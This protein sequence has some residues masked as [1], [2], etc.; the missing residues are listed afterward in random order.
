VALVIRL[1]GVPSIERD[2]VPV[3]LGGRKPWA[4]LAMLALE[5]RPLPRQ[6]LID[7][8]TPEAD[9][10]QAALRWLLHAVRRA[11]GPEATVAEHDGQL[12]LECSEAVEVDVIR[13]TEGS[14]EDGI[15]EAATGELLDGLRFDEPSLAFWL[16]MERTRLKGAVAEALWWTA[17]TVASTD[18]DR[19]MRLVR[20]GLSID[21]YCET[22]HE[23]LI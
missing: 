13:L 10:P 17:V 18:P 16:S 9:D 23:L 8:L 2:A 14:D 6:E 19:S 1:L 20:R 3:R 7:R 15:D 21:P 22:K 4:L 5:G 11:I 12:L